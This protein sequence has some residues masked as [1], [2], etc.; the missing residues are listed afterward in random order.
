MLRHRF[1]PFFSLSLVVAAVLLPPSPSR[2]AGCLTCHGK[3]ELNAKTVDPTRKL[4]LDAAALKKSVHGD[5]D[6]TDCHAQLADADASKPHA[7]KVGPPTCSECHEDADK[8]YRG[9]VHG[10]AQATGKKGMALC[11]DCHGAH[12][13]VKVKDS[14]SRVYK[15]R[16]PF[17][18][19]K[20][21][22]NAAMSKQ[23][24]IQATQAAKHYMESIHG[25]ALLKHG[26]HAAPSCTDCH[27]AHDI[28]PHEHPQSKI[29]HGNVP[30]TCGQCHKVI[31]KVYSKSVHGKTRA[32]GDKKRVPVCID[33]H[34][35]HTIVRP[36]NGKFKLESDRMC[37][38]CHSDRLR[39]YRESYHG[40]AIA[41]G[42]GKVAACYD[43]HGHHD[44]MPSSDSRSHLSQKNILATCRN[45]HPGA[46]PKFVS[47]MAHADHTDKKQYPLL[48]W[49]FICMTSL[50]LC[51]F[52]FFGLHT[53]LWFFRSLRTIMKDPKAFWEARRK[54]SEQIPGKI[55]VRFRPVDRFCHVLVIISFLL[56]VITGMPLK[57]YQAGWASVMF[58]M[59]GGAVVAGALHR[60]GAL[61]TGLYFAIH[62]SR[63][64]FALWS[65]RKDM[66]NANDRFSI[67]GALKVV[68][69][70]DSP[71]PNF[72]DLRDFW[73]HFKWFIG[74]GPRPQ[75]DR[76]T[77]WEKFDYMAVFWGVAVIGLSGLIMWMPEIATK[78]LPGWAINVALVIHSDEALLAA[79]FIFTFH[80]FNSH[81]RPEKIPMDPV[82]FS[83]RITEAE[84]LHERGRQYDRLKEAGLLEREKLGDEYSRWKHI[85]FP[86]GL[87]AFAT[88]LVLVLAIYWAMASRMI[89]G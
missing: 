67:R 23:H 72:Q 53:L 42:L 69:G 50:L 49:A 83:G 4:V 44:I 18:C 76:W 36:T 64:L 59:M 80:F 60:F 77:Y 61:L 21:H 85:I 8:A 79:G 11:A 6:C 89:L 3:A 29:S 41:L 74:R 45:C 5:L 24:N 39:R 25:R 10:R 62:I 12:D 66:R 34:T 58:D 81:F 17:T 47:Y 30:K 70:P 56:L 86:L 52:A 15:M 19:A 51:V 43:C 55:F 28:Q 14:R 73:A 88:G 7:K 63:L 78:L 82:I 54:A 27:G 33:C 2:A 35:A 20:C 37:G 71:V 57:F 31:Q 22:Q 38:Q 40:K 68:L 48:Y 46:G 75:F 9:S 87:L 26:L 65:R 13:I 16:L 1:L 32:K 84:M